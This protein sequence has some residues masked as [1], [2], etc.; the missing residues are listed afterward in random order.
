LPI[1]EPN[2]KKK[3]LTFSHLGK[4]YTVEYKYN[5]NLI[6]FFSTYPQA[7]YESFF[8]AA[9]D[10]MTYVSIAKSL[11]KYINGKKAAEAM[12]FVLNF[13]QNAFEYQTDQ[14]QFG[15]EKVMFAEETLYYK[16]SDCEDRAI[17]YSYLTKELFDVAVLGVKYPNHMATALYV[18]LDGDKIKVKGKEFVIADPTYINANIGQAMPQFKGKMPKE[19]IFVTLK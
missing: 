14:E 9:V 17:L 8:N 5:Q 7:D 16:A 12:N 15:R 13:V 18:P 11:R 6:D 1:F 2:Y 4:K 19:F 10:K 3:T